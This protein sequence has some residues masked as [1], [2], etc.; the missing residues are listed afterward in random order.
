MQKLHRVLRIHILFKHCEE[1]K[2]CLNQ[3]Q[4]INLEINN[5][6]IT[7]NSMYLEIK[8][9]LLN[10]PKVKEEIKTQLRKYFELNDNEN[11]TLSKLVGYS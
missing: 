5:K 10:S 8:K 1:Y 4:R 6:K 9:T 3:F 11:N 7:R 2:I